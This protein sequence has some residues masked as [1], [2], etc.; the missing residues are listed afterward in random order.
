MAF[1]STHPSTHC[2]L[3]NTFF[4]GPWWSSGLEHQSHD[5]LVIFK[6]EGSDRAISCFLSRKLLDKNDSTQNFPCRVTN[7]NFWKGS[8][9]WSGL[10]QGDGSARSRVQ[11]SAAQALQ[12]KKM[13]R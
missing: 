5:V 7:L 2:F 10:A 3:N 4:T 12:N 1:T 13:K 8:A 11:I 9:R 6:V